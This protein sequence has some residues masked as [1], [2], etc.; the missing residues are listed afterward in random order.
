MRNIS[1][2]MTKD[3]VRARTKTV[4]RRLGWDFLKPGDVLQGCEKCQGLGK[5]GK[6]VKLCRIRVTD[7]RQEP[8]SRMVEDIFYGGAEVTAEGFPNL[9]PAGF[10]RLFCASHKGCKPNSIVTRIEFEY[11]D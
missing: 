7:V 3:Q 1:F 10:V 2:S 5:G 8:L 6:I 4:T 11:L 9:P